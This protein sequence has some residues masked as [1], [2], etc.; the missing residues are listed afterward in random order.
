M[1]QDH[2]RFVSLSLTFM[3]GKGT[4]QLRYLNSLYLQ[5]QNDNLSSICYLNEELHMAERSAS[6][7]IQHWCRYSRQFV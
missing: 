4:K 6:I 5:L 2:G 3:L 7:L 1:A